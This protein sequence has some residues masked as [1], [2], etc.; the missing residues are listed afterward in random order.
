MPY[1]QV[2]Y[3]EQIWYLVKFKIKGVRTWRSAKAKA[4]ARAREDA[5]EA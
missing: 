4:V 5:K 2:T 3:L 1:R